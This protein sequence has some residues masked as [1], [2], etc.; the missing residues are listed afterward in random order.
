MDLPVND[1]VNQTI[2]LRCNKELSELTARMQKEKDEQTADLISRGMMRSSM[3]ASFEMSLSLKHHKDL[4]SAELQ[5]AIDVLK[6]AGIPLTEEIASAISA[7]FERRNESVKNNIPSKI[8]DALRRAGLS[9]E[10]A[11]HVDQARRI[12]DSIMHRAKRDLDIAVNTSK[13]RQGA[14]EV[15]AYGTIRDVELALRGFIAQ[16]LA[17]ASEKWE[18]QRVS[19]TVRKRWED[20]LRDRSGKSYPWLDADAA[21]LDMADFTDY[22]AIIEQNNNW[23]EVFQPLLGKKEELVPKLYE[24]QALRNEIAHMRGLSGDASRSLEHLAADVLAR[25]N[26]GI[27][28]SSVAESAAPKE[29][30]S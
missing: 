11:P 23:R 28:A 30:E 8:T 14:R 2:R 6:D 7:H 4:L 16:H 17:V 15:A 1:L 12:A 5:C 18:S 10:A 3:G 9:V 27:V 19:E 13:L 22:S 25:L 26:R 20:R 24:L 29:E 21:L